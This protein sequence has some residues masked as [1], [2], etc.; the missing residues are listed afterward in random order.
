M[1]NNIKLVL[2]FL[3]L[4]ALPLR[5]IAQQPYRQY[6]DDGILMNFHKID[7]VDFRVFLLQNLSQD[8]RFTL[9]ADEEPD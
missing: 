5:Q 1:K 4:M 9:I 8:D 2:A 3:M 7:N 6:A